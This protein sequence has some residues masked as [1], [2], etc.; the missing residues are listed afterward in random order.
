MYFKMAKLNSKKTEKIFVYKEKCLVGLTLELKFSV[1]VV[2]LHQPTPL[3]TK[4]SGG[5]SKKAISTV[6][7]EESILPNFDF[8]VF[9]NFCFKF[10]HFKVKTMYFKCYNHSSLSMKNQKN[11]VLRRKKF[12]RIDSSLSFLSMLMLFISFNCNQSERDVLF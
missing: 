8:F 3:C 6:L 4:G 11:F 1:T 2:F 12:G 10:G 5:T 9:S 7:V